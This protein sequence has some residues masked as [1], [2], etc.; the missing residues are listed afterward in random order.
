MAEQ[1]LL[2]S[3]QLGIG[4]P[5]T[6]RGYATSITRGDHGFLLSGELYSP[7]YS[8]ADCGLFEERIT[9]RFRGL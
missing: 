9:E 7:T 2:A 5:S 6:V 4:G 8:L 1:N 3:E